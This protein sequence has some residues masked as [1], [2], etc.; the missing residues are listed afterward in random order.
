MFTGVADQLP[1]TLSLSGLCTPPA[2][3]HDVWII[4]AVH[5]QVANFSIWSRSVALDSVSFSAVYT[6]CTAMP[7]V[8]EMCCALASVSCLQV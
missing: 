2:Q 1:L 8:H 3:P 7:G 5:E 6:A 4:C